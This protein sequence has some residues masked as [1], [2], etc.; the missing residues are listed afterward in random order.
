MLF[1]PSSTTTLHLGLLCCLSSA[2]CEP[3]ASPAGQRCKHEARLG[4][5]IIARP[6]TCTF[7]GMGGAIGMV[8]N[9]TYTLFFVLGELWGDVV[10]SLLFWGLANE[11]THMSEVGPM[12]QTV[13]RLPAVPLRHGLDLVVAKHNSELGLPRGWLVL[14]RSS[15]IQGLYSHQGATA[16][17]LS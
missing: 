15:A 16:Q 3:E 5:S 7:A 11:L 12:R 10:L 8:R 13:V 2:P 1:A 4:P 14:V 6:L 9:W 17:P